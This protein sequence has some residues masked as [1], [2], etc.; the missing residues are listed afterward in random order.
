MKRALHVGGRAGFALGVAGL[1]VGLAGAPAFAA[2]ANLSVSPSGTIDHN[3]VITASGSYDNS[4]GL[5]SETMKLTVDRPDS[6]SS[7]LYTGSAKAA[8]SGTT[9]T[10]SVD[11]S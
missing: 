7:V 6:S 4:T 10:E 8:S 9:P 11:T 2:S 5:N 3:A 1:V